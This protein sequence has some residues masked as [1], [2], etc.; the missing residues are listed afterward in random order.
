[1]RWIRPVGGCPSKLDGVRAYWDGENFISRLGNVFAVPDDY[2]SVMPKDMHL[3]GEL[4][5]GRGRFQE[6]S[7][8]VRRMDKGRQWKDIQY[9]VFDA[10]NVGGGFEDRQDTLRRQAPKHG[11]KVVQQDFC[12]GHSDLREKLDLIEKLGGEGLMLRKAKSLYERTRSTTLLKV[13]SFHDAEALVT[14]YT[15]GR[16]K[17]KGKVG[18]LRCE[19]PINSRISLLGGRSFDLRKGVR[20]DVGTGLS[21]AERESPPHLGSTITFRFQELS[22]DGVPRFPSFIRVFCA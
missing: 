2:K 7:G 9:M 4:W 15:E 6:T 13:K 11:F 17:H 19:F 1:M 18:A 14:G 20:F 5:M 8:A 10:P 12:T 21:D 3:D 16:G 22:K